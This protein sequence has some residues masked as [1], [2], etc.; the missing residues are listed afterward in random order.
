MTRLTVALPV[1]NGMPYLVPAVESILSQTLQD[2]RFLIIDDGS[3]DGSAD[4]LDSLD[5]PRVTVIHQENRGLG[6]TLNRAIELCDTEYLAR[7]DADDVSH[8]DRLERQ[9]LHME[10]HPDIGLL[11]SQIEFVVGERRFPDHENL[12][13]IPRS[14]IC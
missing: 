5:D 12:C 2:F 3:I 10:S 11:G 9:L 13:V 6:A 1:Y 8:P 14:G 7:M 4:Y